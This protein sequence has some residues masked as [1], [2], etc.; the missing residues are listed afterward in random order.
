[1]V[2]SFTLRTVLRLINLYGVVSQ[3]QLK[4][5][6][7]VCNTTVSTSMHINIIVIVGNEACN[8]LYS[9]RLNS[10][11]KNGNNFGR[12]EMCYDGYWGSVCNDYAFDNTAKVACNEL[13]YNETVKGMFVSL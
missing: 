3:L 8:S 7:Q 1:M 6:V 10:F 12:L 2:Q 13:G 9:L 5:F 4:H 11:G